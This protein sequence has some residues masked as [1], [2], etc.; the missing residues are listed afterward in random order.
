MLNTSFNVYERSVR[1]NKKRL[2]R[3]GLV[4]GVIFGGVLE[5]SIPIKMSNIDF[6]KMI[7]TNNS[8]S[9]ITLK[10][11]DEEL[12]CVVKE[13]QKL[14]PSKILHVSFQYVEPNEKIKMRI[15]IKYIGQEN[16]ESKRLVLETF[17]PFIDFQGDVEK[18]PEFLEINVSNMNC[19]DK[20]F[21]ND[22]NIPNDISILTDPDTLL[23]IANPCE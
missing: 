7:T 19:E 23:A 4:P 2:R 22:I 16:L 17:T 14:S 13:I 5:E 1:E 21:V 20:L 10:L 6:N 8:G 3:T 15:P 11:N 9:I 12:N 18:I